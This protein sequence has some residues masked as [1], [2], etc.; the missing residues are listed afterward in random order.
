VP[1]FAQDLGGA[2][3]ALQALIAHLACKGIVDDDG[4]A[5]GGYGF[6]P[7]ISV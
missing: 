2:G 3:Q 6:T 5:C 1:R 4:L 7:V